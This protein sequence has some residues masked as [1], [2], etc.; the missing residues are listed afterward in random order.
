E[1][2]GRM[3]EQHQEQT[4][5]QHESIVRV[6]ACPS[7]RIVDAGPESP[8][9]RNGTENSATRPAQGLRPCH[10]RAPSVITSDFGRIGACAKSEKPGRGGSAGLACGWPSLLLSASL[11]MA[12]TA[13]GV[14]S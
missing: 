14:V 8:S 9:G 5:T 10:Y 11:M 3:P 7:R 13:R 2:R 4:P 6:G 12:A 1:A